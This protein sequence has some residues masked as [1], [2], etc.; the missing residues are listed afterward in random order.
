MLGEPF[1]Q[2]K[3]QLEIQRQFSNGQ[4]LQLQFY[5]SR[6][7]EA[8]LHEIAQLWLERLE[9][10]WNHE[11]QTARLKLHSNELE[12]LNERF[13]E[14]WKENL[15]ANQILQQYNISL[16]EAVQEKTRELKEAL[17]RAN[18]ANEAKSRFLAN[19]S[20][21]LR[22]P[23][24]GVIALT[25]LT[26]TGNLDSEQRENLEI[27]E[28]SARTL[29]AI[30][31]D[32]LDFSKIEAGK[33]HLERSPFD[34][35][36]TLQDVVDSLSPM[37]LSKGIDFDVTASFPL[38]RHVVGDSLRLKQVL[39]NLAGNAVKFTQKGK[40]SLNLRLERSDVAR[41]HV[42]F[43]VEDTG[44][45][46]PPERIETIFEPFTQA[47]DSTARRFGGTGLGIA[48][49]RQLVELMGG[50]LGV[51]SEP[52]QGSCFYFTIPLL[53]NAS[54]EE[55]TFEDR[56]SRLDVAGLPREL[57]QWME[58]YAREIIFHE[59]VSSIP[60]QE[61]GPVLFT[62][63]SFQKVRP[64]LWKFSR[65]P[66]AVLCHPRRDWDEALP[67]DVRMI[68]IPCLPHRIQEWLESLQRQR[69]P[70]PASGLEPSS[71]HS[72]LLVEDNDIN[73]RATEKLIRHL[74]YDPVC[75][76]SG[77][78]AIRLTEK[79]QPALILMDLMMPGLDGYETTRILRQQLGIQVPILALSAASRRT[80]LKKCLDTGMN[81]FI[82]KPL[83]ISELERTLRQY[84]SPLTKESIHDFSGSA[85]VS[86]ADGDRAFVEEMLDLFED[87][88]P[89]EFQQLQKCLKK[90]QYE[91]ALR[92][93]HSLKN[94][95]G[96]VGGLDCSLA[97]E[98]LYNLLSE[99]ARLNPEEL[100]ACLKQ[101][102][103][104]IQKALRRFG[105]TSNPANPS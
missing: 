75:V 45:G 63:Q 85:L 37:A 99:P 83:M 101:C 65:R 24:N 36:E 3:F 17:A 34:L 59:D 62:A 41:S 95:T 13:T 55:K 100:T 82:G 84:L 51:T 56:P 48:I 86:L 43:E 11:E 32:I 76:A 96:L 30:L 74:G 23:L 91:D 4:T 52:D 97:F 16:E 27:V 40:I 57:E 28:R 93:T 88:V 68:R 71:R 21:E 19:V 70:L 64:E 9:I 15:E 79:I 47:D 105:R 12:N 72:I 39:F 66:I 10:N 29:L 50:E 58:G 8:G 2:E 38:P 89:R 42:F 78:D 22:T 7:S 103:D 77:E 80:E 92:L 69:Q 87:S 53:I 20:H 61:S 94:S 102:E 6:I 1:E 44:V 49:A 98:G 90:D 26:L 35:M 46:I 25:Q 54:A 104:G 5:S 60:A 14:I 18:I 31:N 33:I 81:D 67:V 73:R